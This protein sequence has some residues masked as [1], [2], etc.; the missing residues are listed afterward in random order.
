MSA[1]KEWLKAEVLEVAREIGVNKYDCLV[2][3]MDSFLARWN[4]T[5]TGQFK[6]YGYGKMSSF[7]RTEVGVEESNGKYRIKITVSDASHETE[8]GASAKFVSLVTDSK[9]NST[10]SPNDSAG[11]K[12]EE[13]LHGLKVEVL[14]SIQDYLENST[15]PK[16]RKSYLTL[17]QLNSAWAHQHP[18]DKFKMRGFGSFKSFLAN[19]L[20]L[21]TPEGQQQQDC[22]KITLYDVKRKLECLESREGNRSIT[23]SEAGSNE[24]NQADEQ[25]KGDTTK[26]DDLI[27]GT[28]KN[29]VCSAREGLLSSEN[30]SQSSIQPQPEVPAD[31]ASKG[32]TTGTSLANKRFSEEE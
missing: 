16:Q 24:N 31:S 17:N 8:K 20:N 21:R 18:N 14:T 13:E 9:M 11:P 19:K 2:F 32:T 7:L 4:S 22:F 27:S 10:A 6:Q 29:T 25:H 26:Q 23:N 15:K 12:S 1:N 28:M 30:S 5:H 3:D